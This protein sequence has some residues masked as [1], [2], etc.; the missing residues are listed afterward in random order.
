MN[1]QGAGHA[2]AE[3]EGMK[4]LTGKRKFDGIASEGIALEACIVFRARK[5]PERTLTTAQEEKI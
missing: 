5:G 4:M 1:A 3:P 2:K